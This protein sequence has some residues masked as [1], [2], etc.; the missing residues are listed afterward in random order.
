MALSRQSLETTIKIQ[1]HHF[2]LF[3]FANV[4]PGICD[5]SWFLVVGA[6]VKIYLFS[7][8]W[9]IRKIFKIKSFK[10]GQKCHKMLKTSRNVD[11]FDKYSKSKNNV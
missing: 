2:L 10:K 7:K 5:N 8:C 4:K 3:L 11:K 1:K 6:V 9:E